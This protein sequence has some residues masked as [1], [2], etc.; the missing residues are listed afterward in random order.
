MKKKKIFLLGLAFVAII[1][2][3]LAVYGYTTYTSVVSI[4]SGTGTDYDYFHT[5][6]DKENN[7][8]WWEVEFEAKA[9]ISYSQTNV[10]F[11]VYP[12]NDPGDPDIISRFT[13]YVTDDQW[14]Y[15]YDG[16][17]D[18]YLLKGNADYTTKLQILPTQVDYRNA[19]GT[20]SNISIE[21]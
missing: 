21:E 15:F 17:D 2:L 4:P 6:I 13:N 5:A 3:T 8:V 10:T 11:S 18:A 16:D 14:Y 19:I 1:I 9:W 20:V 12:S 7:N